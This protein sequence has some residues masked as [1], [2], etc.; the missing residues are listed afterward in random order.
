MVAGALYQQFGW[1]A[2][3]A[4][5]AIALLFTVLLGSALKMPQPTPLRVLATEP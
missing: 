1:P 3:V 4:A 5:T 2:C